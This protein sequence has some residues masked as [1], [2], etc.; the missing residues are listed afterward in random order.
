MGIPGDGSPGDSLGSPG[1]REF[2]R[3]LDNDRE[4]AGNAMNWIQDLYAVE[5]QAREEELSPDQRKELRLAR[6]LPFINELGAWIHA[7][8]PD[9][10]PKS[11]IGKA[12]GLYGQA[13]GRSQRLPV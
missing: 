11:Q 8:A 4:R 3:A 9:V 2:E 13:V 12:N 1:R 7:E 5:R 10:L 6:S